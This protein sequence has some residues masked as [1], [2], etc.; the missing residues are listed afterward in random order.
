MTKYA[1]LG[2]IFCCRRVDENY[3]WWKDDKTRKMLEMVESINA[4]R[5]IGR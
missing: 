3:F 1:D 5:D 4:G 2:R